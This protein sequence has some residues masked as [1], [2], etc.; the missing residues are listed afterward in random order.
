MTNDVAAWLRD[1][2]CCCGRSECVAA[3]AKGAAEIERLEALLVKQSEPSGKFSQEMLTSI[4]SDPPIVGWVDAARVAEWAHRV[5]GLESR[6]TEPPA[7]AVSL[8]ERRHEVPQLIA[9]IEAECEKLDSPGPDEYEAGQ[10]FAYR[11]VLA[12][13]RTAEQNEVK[14]CTCPPDDNPPQPCP[15]KYALSE[16]RRAADGYCAPCHE[17]AY[18]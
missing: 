15:R 9:W 11:A 10:S 5:A 14:P 16:C 1:P 6:Q 7:E 3:A 18:P 17:A 4:D 13:L 8:D 2:Y 12:R